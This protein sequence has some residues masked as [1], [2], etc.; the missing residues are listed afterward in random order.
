MHTQIILPLSWRFVVYK[1]NNL[2]L[3][4]NISFVSST[5]TAIHVKQSVY[6]CHP[7][8]RDPIV[9]RWHSFKLMSLCTPVTSKGFSDCLTRV[10]EPMALVLDG[11]AG[12]YKVL[13]FIIY[14]YRSPFINHMHP[15]SLIDNVRDFFQFEASLSWSYSYLH[16]VNSK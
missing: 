15:V 9:K 8:M 11:Q 3:S 16:K 12:C 13:P 6:F 14:I 10:Y 1:I 2:I 5:S 7:V 4:T